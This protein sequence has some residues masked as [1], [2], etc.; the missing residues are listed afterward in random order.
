MASDNLLERAFMA[1]IRA[2]EYREDLAALQKEFDERPDVIEIKRLIERCEEERR[3]AIAKAKAAGISKQG[4]FLL[5]I[6]TRKQRT[7]IPE[8]FFARFGAETFVRCSTV[9]I[10]K[11]EAL[12]G[13]GTFDDCCE[14][15]VKEI[16]VTVEYERPGVSE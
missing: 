6:R 11:A 14:V 8:R 10:G 4:N 9:A 7:V 3:Q 5:K 16:G 2:D 13:K 1:R 12:L 15:E